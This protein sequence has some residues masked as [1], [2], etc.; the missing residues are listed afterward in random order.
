MDAATRL[1]ADRLAQR[2]QA[3]GEEAVGD[4]QHGA[5]AMAVDGTARRRPDGHSVQTPSARTRGLFN[6]WRST[7]M[8]QPASRLAVAAVLAG[9]RTTNENHPGFHRGGDF[10]VS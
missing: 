7:T 8:K 5:P 4:K 1:D 2:G 3:G 10:D 9:A 6:V